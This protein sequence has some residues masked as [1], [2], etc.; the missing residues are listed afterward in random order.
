MNKRNIIIILFSFYSFG[1]YLSSTSAPKAGTQVRATNN[2]TDNHNVNSD[3]NSTHKP[4]HS[5]IILINL[6]N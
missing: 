2:S 6:F 4:F 1:G 3:N 5:W